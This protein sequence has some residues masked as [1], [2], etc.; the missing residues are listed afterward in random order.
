MNNLPMD[1]N[2]FIYVPD[3]SAEDEFRCR[4]LL[5]D[6]LQQYIINGNVRG[7][8]TPFELNLGRGE[9][10]EKSL[11]IIGVRNAACKGELS[12]EETFRFGPGSSGRIISCSH[13]LTPDEFSTR[14]RMVINLE[15]GA[16]AEFF[17]MQ[18]EHNKA[19]HDLRCDISLAEGASLRM[20]FISLH[21]GEINNE[22]N[23]DL[24]G[25][26]ADC[27]LSGLYLTDTGQKM[28]NSV[29]LRH[30]VPDCHSNQLF[31]GILNDDGVSKFY[32]GI[33]V[34]PDAQHT[35]A[36]Q[37]NHNLLL[38]DSSR[39][40][41]KPQLEIYADDVKCSHGATVGRLDEDELFYMRTRGITADEA[42]LLQQMAFAYEVLERITSSE[43]R[44]RVLS[45]VE[46]R[47]RGDFAT[48]KGCTKNCC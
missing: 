37:A 33:L 19:R 34:A 35:E 8:K 42:R 7:G 20:V 32:G 27:D 40:Y 29:Q 6:N 22:I 3:L 38:S 15:E 11:Q 5:P 39:A 21:G 16:S 31:K 12:F 4:V 14:E 25:P 48:C 10:M 41:S 23:V 26:H 36:F 46:G 17:V 18:N 1:A 30:L 45:L 24:N 13:T 44:E 2:Q 28:S 43:L 47:L 9:R